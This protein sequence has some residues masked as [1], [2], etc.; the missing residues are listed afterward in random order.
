MVPALKPASAPTWFLPVTAAPRQ[1]HVLH[2]Y[3]RA[4]I[5]K[6]SDVVGGRSIDV[7]FAMV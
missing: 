6:Q 4:D 7:R 1:T 2:R 3:A 5:A